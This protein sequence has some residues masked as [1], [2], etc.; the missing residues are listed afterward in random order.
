MV[1]TW[2]LL[3]L[4]KSTASYLDGR[5]I[6]GGRRDAE[7]LLG[8]VL[9]LDRVG[10]YLNFERPVTVAELDTY[11]ELVR[12]RAA[13]EPLQYILGETE[14]WSLPL[15]VTPAVLV[16]R[17]DT[18]VLVEEALQRLPASGNCLDIGTGSGAIAIALAHE[19]PAASFT[20]IDI[21]PAALAVARDN[22]ERHAVSGRIAFAE[23]DLFQLAAGCFDLIVSNPPY[24]RCG[25]LAG[26]MPEVRDFEP[27]RALDGGE[28]G[29]DAY[30]ALTRQA[31]ARLNFGGWLL[32]EIGIDQA[33]AVRELFTAAGFTDIFMR[34]DYAGIDRVI[35][36]RVG[37]DRGTEI[38]GCC[39]D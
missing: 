26:L 25:D 30:R 27:R 4:L 2:T 5:G 32:V 7:L 1:E 20:A 14:F 11:R 10:L 28:D 34:A 21:D 31:P 23:G 35:G 6:A 38:S 24:I 17:S 18:E 13:R 15:R 29:L 36:G 22:A 37:S 3:N 19:R 9:K 16:P 8:Q 33:A 12:R 39:L